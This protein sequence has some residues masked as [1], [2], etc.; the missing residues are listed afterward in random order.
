[1]NCLS[2]LFL[3][4]ISLGALGACPDLTKN[5]TAQ[6]CPWA[7]ITRQIVDQKKLCDPVLKAH[8]PFIFKQLNKDQKSQEFLALWGEAKNYDENAK[9]I[10]VEV[11][12]LQCLAEKLNL[13]NSIQHQNGFESVHAGLQHTYAYLFS[14]TQTPYGYKRARWTK[15]DIERGFGL[16]KKA[17]TP[18]TKKG[19]FLSNVTY[20]FAKFAF[21]DDFELIKKLEISGRKNK[22]VSTELIALKAEKFQIKNLKESLPEKQII[23]HTIFVKMNPK[24]IISKNTH[25]LIYWVEDQKNKTKYLITGFPVETSFVDKALDEKKLGL[26]KPIITRYNAWISALTNSQESLVG[27]REAIAN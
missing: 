20:F 25:L 14:N 23:L 12:I 13:K 24:K 6:D 7:E 18:E 22:S 2:V 5:E 16:S 10:I 15:D 17:L 11:K 1:M 9:A 21:R 8:V 27:L 3:V 19:A 4:F 26:K